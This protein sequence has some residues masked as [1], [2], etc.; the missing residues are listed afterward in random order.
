[1]KKIISVILA[2]TLIAVSCVALTACNND[3]TVSLVSI[4]AE[5]SENSV[6]KVGDTFNTSLFNV[7][8]VFSDESEKAVVTT[9][10]LTFDKSTLKLVNNK[11]T[12]AGEYT[13]KIKFLDRLETSLTFTVV[14]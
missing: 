10:S 1:M 13:M 7:T 11:Y 2:L 12:E 6:I 8:G 4:K 3:E 5:L 9:E 14:A